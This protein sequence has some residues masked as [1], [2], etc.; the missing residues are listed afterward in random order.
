[1]FSKE[2]KPEKKDLLMTQEEEEVK[3]RRQH[4]WKPI[5]LRL[6][7]L[8]YVLLVTSAL[9]VVLQWLL[10]TSQTIGGV[11][12]APSINDLPL[13]KTFGY[14]YAPTIIAV[15]YGLLW[16]WIDLDIKRMEPYYQLCSSGGALAENSLLLQYPFDFVALVPF[17]AARR[18][19]WSVLTAALAGVVVLWTL[20][21]LQAGIFATENRVVTSTSPFLTST[22]YQ[23]ASNQSGPSALWAQHAYNIAWLNEKLPPYSTVD[24]VLDAFAPATSHAMYSNEVWNGTTKLYS[25]DVVCE[26]TIEY[27]SNP[28]SNSPNTKYNSSSGCSYGLPVKTGTGN[29]TS[30]TLEAMYV[31]YSDQNGMADW[32]LEG[33]CPKQANHIFLVRTTLFSVAGMSDQT[34]ASTTTP[35]SGVLKSTSLYCEPRYY[36]QEVNASVAAANGS[37]ITTTPI[38]QKKDLPREMFE[39]NLFERAMSSGL[40]YSGPGVSYD[41]GRG[42]FP[43]N[44]WPDQKTH[45]TNTN[46]DMSYLPKMV[47]FSFA[48]FRQPKLE[49]YLDPEILAQS[50][51][52]AYRLLFVAQMTRILRS[53]LGTTATSHD[54]QSTY[55]T[56]ALVLVPGFTYAVEALLVLAV[57]FN[58]SIIYFSLTRTCNLQSDPTSIASHM[59]ATADDPELLTLL[60]GLDNTSAADIRN[61]LGGTKFSLSADAKIELQSAPV[62]NPNQDVNTEHR[63]QSKGVQSP[64]LRW[65]SGVAFLTIQL[66]S[67][68]VFSYLF[69]QAKINN[70]KLP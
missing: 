3:A 2:Q 65:Y 59:S 15:V 23:P 40:D 53:D 32:Y 16:S 8:T 22:A 18:K 57:L 63:N 43:E 21:P 6:P 20:T 5:S 37:V 27:I 66:A 62:M 60:S 42:D 51:Q 34:L 7:F 64:E 4:T 38:G 68:A 28:W 1:M 35:N 17:Q 55:Q 26:P 52:S 58:L 19:H 9:I 25:V 13:S 29:D 54:G 30:K 70:G 33:Y 45:F 24:F 69:H 44:T 10:Y 12:F 36:E 41:S 56:Q 67:I 48:A 31:G 39:I 14:L 61:A 11:I 46:L 50:Y 49:D 47:P